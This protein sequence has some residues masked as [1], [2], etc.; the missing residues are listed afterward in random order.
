MKPRLKF[1]NNSVGVDEAGRGSWAGP[2]VAAAVV[3]LPDHKIV[4]LND[5]KKLSPKKRLYL[6]EAIQKNQKYA[7]GIATVEEICRLNILQATFLAM[8]RAIENLNHQAQIFLID[9]NINPDLGVTS[10]AII[11][12][13]SIYEQI[14]AAS[15]VAKVVRDQIMKELDLIHPEYN[16]R[17]NAGYGTAQHLEKLMKFGPCQHHRKTFKPI[18]N[19][20]TNAI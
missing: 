16:W 6:F 4:G 9:G 2:V 13:D 14:A 8:K 5:S 17:N 15:I 18:T 20:L 7:V 3:L 19:F 1:I 11:K 10:E 12:G